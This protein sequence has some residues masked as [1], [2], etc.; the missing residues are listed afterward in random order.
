[1]F[2]CKQVSKALSEEEYKD[3]PLIRRTLVRLHVK[4]CLICGKYNNQVIDSQEMC[5]CY[6]QNE[7]SVA[8]SRPKMHPSKKEELNKLL[9]SH[10]DTK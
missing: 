8:Q 6:K 7:D 2:T 9:Q 10:I 1:M 5:Q 3:M 4:L